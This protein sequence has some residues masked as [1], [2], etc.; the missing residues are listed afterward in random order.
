MVQI[1]A[2]FKSAARL[3]AQNFHE[4]KQLRLLNLMRLWVP[5]G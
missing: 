4:S 3:F 2:V 5:K 1:R